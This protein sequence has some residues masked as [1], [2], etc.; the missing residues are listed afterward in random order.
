MIDTLSLEFIGA[1]LRSIQAEQR[2]LRMENALLRE[3]IAG[4]ATQMATQMA[5]RKELL[6]V[7][8]VLVE[9]IANFEAL[10]ETRL[11][12]LGT[13]L[14]GRIDWLGEQIAGLAKSGA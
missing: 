14:D 9:R 5:T 3:S 6:E 2:T 4:L 7:L 13:H 8:N 11:D 10:T 12:R 1:T